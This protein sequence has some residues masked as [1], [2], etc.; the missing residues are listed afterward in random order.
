MGSYGPHNW[1]YW[2]VGPVWSLSLPVP[3]VKRAPLLSSSIKI[4]NWTTTIHLSKGTWPLLH[5]FFWGT[6]WHCCLRH[7]ATSR[8]VA[9]SFP[10]GVIGIFHWHN[11]SSHN[12]G[13]QTDSTSNRNEYQKYFLRGKGIGLTTL[14]HSCADCRASG[15]FHVKEKFWV[16]LRVYDTWKVSTAPSSWHSLSNCCILM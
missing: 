1:V 7:C 14:P 6:Q 4:H 3:R 16:H 12:Y 10:N 5:T 15:S 9:G 2:H 11:L 8:K 13:P